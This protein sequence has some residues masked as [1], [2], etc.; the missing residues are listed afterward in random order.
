MSTSEM[1]KTKYGV[2]SSIEF[3]MVNGRYEQ[4][5]DLAI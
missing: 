3:V 1:Y 5:E 4:V 2:L